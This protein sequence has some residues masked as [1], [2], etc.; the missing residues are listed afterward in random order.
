MEAERI[1][2]DTENEN[3][4]DYLSDSSSSSQ[5]SL[6]RRYLGMD[7]AKLVDKLEP[8]DDS[9]HG[10]KY[11]RKVEETIEEVKSDHSEEFDDQKS[12]LS[13]NSRSSHS[14]RF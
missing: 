8:L 13:S 6:Q 5:F 2:E 9:S 10:F 3:E 1:S 14:N 11:S 7:L 4:N 12:G